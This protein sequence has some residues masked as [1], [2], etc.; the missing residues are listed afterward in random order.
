[1]Y[2]FLTKYINYSFKNINVHNYAKS[3]IC[4]KLLYI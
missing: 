2:I 3:V 4:I 1:M